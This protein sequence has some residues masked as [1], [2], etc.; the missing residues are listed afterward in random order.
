MSYVGNIIEE[1]RNNT[2]FRKVIFT[3]EK[4]QLVVMNIP[5][6]GEI[7][8]EVHKH[9]EQTLVVVE[10]NAKVILDGEVAFLRAGEAVVVL[11][12]VEHNLLNAADID[13]K[14]YTIYAP[15]NHI[16]GRI[17]ITKA[18]ADADTLDE[19]FGHGVK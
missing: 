12:G 15:A 1:T 6:G 4:S 17:H 19:E 13:L 2:N 5:V 7:G 16:D 9:V 10:G 8:T 3:G 11:P 14:L 18:A